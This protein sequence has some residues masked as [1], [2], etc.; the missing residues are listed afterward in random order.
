MS[1]AA[2]RLARRAPAGRVFPA[3]LRLGTVRWRARG[4]GQVQTCL[5][6][7]EGREVACDV[8]M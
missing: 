5:E 6:A 8:T 1:L 2:R 3:S 4:Y 7:V